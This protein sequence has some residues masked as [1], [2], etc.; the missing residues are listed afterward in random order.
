MFRPA[1]GSRGLTPRVARPAPSEARSRTSPDG[2][3]RNPE[4]APRN[5]AA[6]VALLAHGGDVLPARTDEPAPAH[7]DVMLPAGLCY[8]LAERG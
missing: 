7:A 4:G 8:A 3:P 2:A 6:A 5:T 1:T